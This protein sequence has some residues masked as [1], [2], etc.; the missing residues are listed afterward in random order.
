KLF[1]RRLEEEF[2]QQLEAVRSNLADHANARQIYETSVRPTA[3]SLRD[4][5]AHFAIS[6]L[7]QRRAEETPTYCYSV[8]RLDYNLA[9]A[10]AA[11][12]ATGQALVTS[13]ITEESLCMFF[14]VL[15]FGDNNL[16]AGVDDQ[17]DRRQY[18]ALLAE[19]AGVFQAFDLP[20]TVRL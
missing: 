7:F 20:G 10:G 14:A 16:A 9:Q 3:I 12:L 19:S 5:G 15:H 17:C 13:R 11:R 2:L 8:A 1:G 6:S 18:E 4:V